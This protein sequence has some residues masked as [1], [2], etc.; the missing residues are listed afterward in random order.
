VRFG[1]VEEPISTPDPK[2]D[3]CLQQVL[4][5]SQGVPPSGVNTEEEIQK[6]AADNYRDAEGHAFAFSHCVE[7]LHQLPKFNPMVDDADRSLDVAVEDLDGDKKPAASVNKI[8]APMGASLKRPPGSKKAKKELL[9]RDTS[10]SGSTVASV[11]METMAQSH[12]ALVATQNRLVSEVAHQTRVQS[13]K[14]QMAG[15]QMKCTIYQ[16]MGND[17]AVR[18]FVSPKLKSCRQNLLPSGLNLV[19]ERLVLLRTNLLLRR[20]TSLER[21]WC[22]STRLPQM[23]RWISPMQKWMTVRKLRTVRLSKTWRRCIQ[24]QKS[25]TNTTEKRS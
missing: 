20:W 6:V 17:G 19:Q 23:R 1:V 2:E 13:S 8:G 24:Q 7:V 14:E 25:R 12:S 16:G 3:G 10:L 21:M 22:F 5:A 4:Q 18:R 9:F 15:E 11:A